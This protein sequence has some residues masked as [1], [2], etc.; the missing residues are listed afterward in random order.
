MAMVLLVLPGSTSIQA[1][2]KPTKVNASPAQASRCFQMNLAMALIKPTYILLA[3]EAASC[4][5]IIAASTACC[6]S[7]RFSGDKSLPRLV[8]DSG[9]ESANA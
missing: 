7:L 4:G 8:T 1:I 5:K 6:A 3:I 9:R 2:I